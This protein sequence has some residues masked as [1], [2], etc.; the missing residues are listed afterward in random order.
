[1]VLIPESI[2]ETVHWEEKI[3]NKKEPE[4]REPQLV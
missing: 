3:R 2:F 4:K 1:M